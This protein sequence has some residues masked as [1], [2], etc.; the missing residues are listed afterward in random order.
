MDYTLA[1]AGGVWC[2]GIACLGGVR[3]D[4]TVGCGAPRSDPGRSRAGLNTLIGFA[5]EKWTNYVRIAA[6]W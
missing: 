2:R 6:P 3:R 1:G 4:E 5:G